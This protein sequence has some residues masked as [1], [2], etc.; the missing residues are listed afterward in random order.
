MY[1]LHNVYLQ[2]GFNSPLAS[3]LLYLRVYTPRNTLLKREICYSY[4]P[5]AISRLA[6][7]DTRGDDPYAPRRMLAAVSLARAQ[8]GLELQ[9]KVS[10]PS[11]LSHALTS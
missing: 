4:T 2:R 3:S 6:A 1:S 9:D 7:R 11:A 10:G 5:L 8:M